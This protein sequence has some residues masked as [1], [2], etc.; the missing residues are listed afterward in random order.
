M[1][2]RREMPETTRSSS[3]LALAPGATRLNSL[4]FA[5]SPRR[6]GRVSFSS[7]HL[8]IATRDRHDPG[9]HD[10]DSEET[11]DYDVEPH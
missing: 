5:L 9:D 8:A 7:P 2:L 11:E 1:R 6:L 10:E 3:S 4:A